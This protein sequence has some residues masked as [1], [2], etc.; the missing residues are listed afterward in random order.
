MLIMAPTIFEIIK[1]FLIE[2]LDREEMDL[3]DYDKAYVNIVRD[4]FSDHF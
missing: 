1:H 3:L 2:D 4:H